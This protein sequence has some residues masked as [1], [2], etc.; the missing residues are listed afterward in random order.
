[1]TLKPSWSRFDAS[2]MTTLS[3]RRDDSVGVGEGSRRA[4]LDA[5]ACQNSHAE[6]TSGALRQTVFNVD[7]DRREHVLMR[8]R[9]V[10]EVLL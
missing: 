6:P 1:M 8:L 5:S 3:V 10:D 7:F 9:D 4:E 2:S